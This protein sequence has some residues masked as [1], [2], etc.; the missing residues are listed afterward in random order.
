MSKILNNW[1]L[2]LLLC[3]TLGLAPFFP[4][5]HVWGKLKWIA[6]GGVGMQLMDWLDLL[7]HGFPFILLLR[8]IILKFI[9]K[10]I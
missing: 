2:L 10:K 9:L 5:P 3:L 8:Y 7:F 6:G 1:K 4:E